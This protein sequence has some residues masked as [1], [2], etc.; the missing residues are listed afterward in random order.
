MDATDKLS[1]FLHFFIF[2]IFPIL[3]V[4]FI[5]FIFLYFVLHYHHREA[6][7]ERIKSFYE[8]TRPVLD[9]YSQTIDVVRDKI[10][11]TQQHYV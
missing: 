1:Y 6:V 10:Y 2:V 8:Q 7:D 4:I 3:F 9:A 5:F 11:E